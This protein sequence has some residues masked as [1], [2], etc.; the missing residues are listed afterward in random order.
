M[1][2]VVR[3]AVRLTTA[4][5]L[6]A[7]GYLHALL[8]RDGYRAV[9]T[10]GTSFLLL[11]SASFAVAVLVAVGAPVLIRLL[12]VGLAS[13]ALAGFVLS[14]TVGIAG[15][16]ERGLQPAPQALES[17]A[18]ETLTVLLATAGLALDDRRLLRPRALAQAAKRLA[19]RRH[20]VPG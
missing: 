2:T 19:R 18:A 14:R 1:R 3:L 6:A 5:S 12:A 17:L 11:A 15:F 9:P 20:A 10:I 4:A 7:V 13:G 8:Y 16:V